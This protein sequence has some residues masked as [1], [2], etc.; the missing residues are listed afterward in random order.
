MFVDKLIVTLITYM[1]HDYNV[2]R[3]QNTLKP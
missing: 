2:L 1:S 3:H